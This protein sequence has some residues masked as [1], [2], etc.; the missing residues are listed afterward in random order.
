MKTITTDTENTQHKID[1]DLYFN[2]IET[3]YDE[4][5]GGRDPFCNY[6][7]IRKMLAADLKFFQRHEEKLKTT[8]PGCYV[9]AAILY[10]I[11]AMFINKKCIE[12]AKKQ[13]G[14]DVNANSRDLYIDIL[15]ALRIVKLDMIANC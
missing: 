13:H 11:Y 14:K 8:C 3:F 12:I 7:A 4:I 2:A 15:A 10:C 6:H 1:N 5:E 9:D